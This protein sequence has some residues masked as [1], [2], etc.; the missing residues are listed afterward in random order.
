MVSRIPITVYILSSNLVM[1]TTVAIKKSS[2][3]FVVQH[4]FSRLY[5]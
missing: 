5:V 4:K 2:I 3:D 1:L